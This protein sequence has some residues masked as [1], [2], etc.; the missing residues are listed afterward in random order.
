M[1]ATGAEHAR[2]RPIEHRLAEALRQRGARAVAVAARVG[3]AV[4]PGA[5]MGRNTAERQLA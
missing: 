1:A 3:H 4:P 2:V 5:K